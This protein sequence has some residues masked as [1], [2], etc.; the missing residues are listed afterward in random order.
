MGS[1]AAH[2]FD[3]PIFRISIDDLIRANFLKKEN[4]P[5]NT[6]DTQYTHDTHYNDHDP[7]PASTSYGMHN[8]SHLN[9]CCCQ[10]H[11]SSRS[12][13]IHQDDAQSYHRHMTSPSYS[14]SH[15]LSSDNAFDDKHINPHACQLASPPP[16]S[17]PSLH[18]QASSSLS[19]VSSSSQPSQANVPPQVSFCRTTVK[20][21]S[22]DTMCELCGK[23]FKKTGIKNH[24]IK[25]HKTTYR[26]RRPVSSSELRPSSDMLESP[27]KFPRRSPPS[28]L[29]NISEMFRAT[30]GRI[31]SL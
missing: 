31:Y 14:S 29:E 16:P 19:S 2:L 17:H 27:H 8:E 12:S 15:A 3:R 6:Q 13:H 18:S 7:Q 9:Q 10:A 23:Y 24:V 1:H 25:A 11:L 4:H 22:R 28:N 21:T 5:Q 30:F 20:C 26:Q